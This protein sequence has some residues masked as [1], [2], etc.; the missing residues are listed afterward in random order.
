MEFLYLRLYEFD[1]FHPSLIECHYLLIV[2]ESSLPPIHT[3]YRV[4]VHTGDEVE[5][6]EFTRYPDRF[7]SRW[8]GDVEED[9]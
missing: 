5:L 1:I 7:G 9:K 3:L 8:I 2:C 6:Q 4:I